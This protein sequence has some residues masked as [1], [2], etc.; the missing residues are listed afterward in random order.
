M[1][2]CLSQT[3]NIPIL[4]H[5]QIGHNDLTIALAG[6]RIEQQTDG[7]RPTVGHR[8]IALYQGLLG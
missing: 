3:V 8:Y 1:G 7:L 2:D 4:A 5:P 6:Y